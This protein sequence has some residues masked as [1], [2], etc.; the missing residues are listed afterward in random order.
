VGKVLR[1][2]KTMWAQ[3]EDWSMSAW[4]RSSEGEKVEEDGW[5]MDDPV[6]ERRS[7]V[8]GRKRIGKRDRARER[9]DRREADRG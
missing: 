6:R 2:E 7:W 5:E 9:R 1:K 3:V 4:E 8:R